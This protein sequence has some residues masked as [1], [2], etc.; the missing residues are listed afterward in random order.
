MRECKTM[1]QHYFKI[2]FR[3]IL[4]NTKYYQYPRFGSRLHLLRPCQ[5]VDTLRNDV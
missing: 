1:I 4:K 5:P 2:A 3:N